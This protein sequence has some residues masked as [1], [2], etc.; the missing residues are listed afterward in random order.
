MLTVQ[1]MK[2]VEEERQQPVENEQFCPQSILYAFGIRLFAVASWRLIIYEARG[3]VV[4]VSSD[5][6]CVLTVKVE[7]CAQK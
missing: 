1:N 2:S 6:V 5:M 7:V 4:L 3:G